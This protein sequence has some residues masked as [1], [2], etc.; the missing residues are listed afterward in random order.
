[1]YRLLHCNINPAMYMAQGPPPHAES[2]EQRIRSTNHETS[3]HTTTKMN[4]G[5][6]H[7]P[8]IGLGV[9]S[10]DHIS[11]RAM[12]AIDRELEALFNLPKPVLQKLHAFTSGNNFTA[13]FWQK[14][15]Q[16]ALDLDT[17]VN[18]LTP[19]TPTLIKVMEEVYVPMVADVLKLTEQEIWNSS[20]EIICYRPFCGGLQS[21]I[22][23]VT[24]TD[25]K[26]G[27][28]CSI[29]FVCERDIDLL[30]VFVPNGRPM[31]VHT[32]KG[33]LLVMD[34]DARILWSHSVPYGAP[35]FRYSLIIR[36]VKLPGH[37]N[38]GLSPLDTVI[39]NP[40]FSVGRE[41]GNSI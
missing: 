6:P 10:P 2:L 13:L 22:D 7:A 17:V 26:M 9:F 1:M 19:F 33:D 24:R 25:G 35:E 40:T 39:P 11:T 41:R 21:H 12:R 4:A 3:I 8:P 23:N 31:R 36:P 15:G 28:I 18:M 27:P 30:P 16:K 32:E 20:A 14:H 29:N 5:K 37:R 34:S 38:R